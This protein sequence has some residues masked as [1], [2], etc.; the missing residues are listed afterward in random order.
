MTGNANYGTNYWKKVLKHRPGNKDQTKIVSN[1]I[2]DILK[3]AK[4]NGKGWRGNKML[5]QTMHK[6]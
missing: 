4:R 5:K 1:K 3:N 6:E 2:K